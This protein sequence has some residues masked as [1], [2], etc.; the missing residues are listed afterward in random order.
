M[1]QVLFSP[2]HFHC[3][4]LETYMFVNS[5][6][7]LLLTNLSMNSSN[8]FEQRNSNFCLVHFWTCSSFSI[9]VYGSSAMETVFENVVWFFSDDKFSNFFYSNE[10][11][12]SVF[13]TDS[14]TKSEKLNSN[15]ILILNEQTNMIKFERT[16][17][18]NPELLQKNWFFWL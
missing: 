5:S 17:A 4:G 6:N 14:L 16:K 9:S 7:W 10:K 11:T 13:P 2:L 3:N 1:K 18:Q 12:S 15:S 8:N